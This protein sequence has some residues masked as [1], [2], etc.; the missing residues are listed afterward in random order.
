MKSTLRSIGIG[1]LFMYVAFGIY[2]YLNQHEFLYFPTSDTSSGYPNMTLQSG[3]Q[4]T[5]V[6]V[7]NEG[8]QN[9]IL[10][11]GGNAESMAGSA[12]YIAKQFPHL[13]VYLLD[14]RGYG[15]STGIASEEDLYKDA[16]RLYDTV[17]SKH[18]RISVGGR[19]LGSGIA[20]YVAAHK[21]V[22]RLVLITPF[23]SVVDV[24]QS[25]YP[26]YPVSLLLK[27][28]YD[29]LSRVQRIKAETLIIFAQNDKVIP[30][31]NT[32]RLI[33]AFDKHTLKV[34]LIQGRGH[35]DISSDERYYKSVQEFIGEG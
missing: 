3:T 35:H 9:A 13:T 12:A 34:I 18:E 27:E 4:S 11:F 26:L 16:L 31:E 8:H 20:T 7:V 24:A 32:Q 25:L 28:R 30:R 2:L 33:D 6:I 14:Y 17:R 21:E 5:N 1:L 23:D 10:Y 22:Y 29:S 19:S 15:K